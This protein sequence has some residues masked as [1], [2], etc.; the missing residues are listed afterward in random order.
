MDA[1][2]ELTE[3]AD[4][5]A[6]NLS[7]ATWGDRSERNKVPRVEFVKPVVEPPE[8]VSVEMTPSEQDVYALMGVSPL[9]KLNREVK[10]PKSV[11]INVTLPGQSSTTPV[12]SS[13]QAS[14]TKTSGTAVPPDQESQTLTESYSSKDAALACETEANSADKRRRR[15]RSRALEPED[16]ST[17]ET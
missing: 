15:R 4:L 13:S 1:E 5:S 9:V 16:T 17:L 6:T 12:E 7:K 11:I 14:S 10:N 8:I 2:A 3:T